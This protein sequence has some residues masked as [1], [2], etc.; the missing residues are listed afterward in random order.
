MTAIGTPFQPPVIHPLWLWRHYRQARP[1]VL[2]SADKTLQQ[3]CYQ[4]Q[5][6]LL[7][8]HMGFSSRV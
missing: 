7:L 6:C 8:L 5:Q 2:G 1:G 4:P 3:P